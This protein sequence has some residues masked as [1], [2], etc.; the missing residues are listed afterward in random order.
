MLAEDVHLEQ[1]IVD[2]TSHRALRVMRLAAEPHPAR[3]FERREVEVRAA[4]S[5][6]GLQLHEAKHSGSPEE[7]LPHP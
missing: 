7:L 6:A 5:D 1:E 4:L 2:A 3:A